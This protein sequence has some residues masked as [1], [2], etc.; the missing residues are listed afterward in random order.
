MESLVRNLKLDARV[1][2]LGD[3]ADVMPY[4]HAA[5]IFAL[6]STAR[7]EAF[8]IVQVE[9]MACGLPVINTQL[10]TGV[11]FVSLD[12]VTGLTVPPCDVVSLRQSIQRL[13]QDHALHRQFSVAARERVRMH[14][15][16]EN[17]AKHT[18]ALY[19]DVLSARV[20]G[21]QPE[22]AAAHD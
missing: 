2:F 4:Y 11:P 19:E 9:A 17:M 10:E 22:F 16:L 20:T 14:F 1:H 6:P 21:S 18:L 12:A 13:L 7:S 15:T 5:R 3:V 8:G